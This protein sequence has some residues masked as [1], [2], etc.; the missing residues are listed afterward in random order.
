V[1]RHEGT[2]QLFRE[3]AKKGYREQLHDAPNAASYL[4]ELAGQIIDEKVT[5]GD[6]LVD[7]LVAWYGGSL[8][9]ETIDRFNK[10]DKGLAGKIG[11]AAL[12]VSR[13]R[14]NQK[15]FPVNATYGVG[16]V[17]GEGLVCDLM[18]GEAYV[19]TEG[20]LSF[21]GTRGIV[22]DRRPLLVNHIYACGYDDEY[23]FLAYGTP[24]FAKEF[25]VD[26][27]IEKAFDPS[28]YASALDASEARQPH[29]QVFV[30]TE[31]VR[32]FLGSNQAVIERV[33]TLGAT[34]QLE[35]LLKSAA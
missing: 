33:E 6:E 24:D 30:G 15:P 20:S 28:D 26:G 5:T 3:V 23:R 29:V 8:T 22:Q 35:D 31:V 4:E 16:L 1:I 19:P 32:N 21:G 2:T 18:R 25:T 34:Q 13:K 12:V 14:P 10:L 17:N 27:R 7:S 9:K 11:Q